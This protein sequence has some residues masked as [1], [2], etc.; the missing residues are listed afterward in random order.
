MAS[1]TA[2]YLQKTDSV[3][4]GEGFGQQMYFVRKRSG[5][6]NSTDVGH[7]AVATGRGVLK[8]CSS[9]SAGVWTPALLKEVKH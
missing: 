1:G 8:L 9:I 6:N 4:S 7:P 2:L 5:S 3:T